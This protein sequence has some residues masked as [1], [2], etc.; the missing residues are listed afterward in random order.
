MLEQRDWLPNV[1]LLQATSTLEVAGLPI[2]HPPQRL[3][4]VN[5]KGT[6]V[7]HNT[8]PRERYPLALG[9]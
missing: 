7:N 4:I 9:M 1:L 8:P 3:Y 2:L 6:Y 5:T